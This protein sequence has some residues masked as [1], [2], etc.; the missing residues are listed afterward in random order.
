MKRGKDRGIL[1]ALMDLSDAWPVVG[2]GLALGLA[3][4]GGYCRWINPKL[5]YGLGPVWAI[6]AWLLAALLGGAATGGYLRRRILRRARAWRLGQVRT[7]D[8]LKALPPAE[9]EQVIADHFRREGY[10]VTE[11]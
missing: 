10:R 2:L 9:F 11:T 8:D 5:M 1:S 3:A 4:L 7:L 6:L